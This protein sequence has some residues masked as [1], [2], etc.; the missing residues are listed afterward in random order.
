MVAARKPNMGRGPP[1]PPLQ[2]F[3]G[4]GAVC[5]ATT[6][7]MVRAFSIPLERPMLS[8]MKNWARTLRRDGH[9]IYFAARDPRVPWYAKFLAIVVAGYALSPIDL[10]PDF[11]PVIGY[12]DD[13]II[14]PFGIWLVVQLV[15][16]AIMAEC[17]SKADE[18]EARPAS[19]TGMV[20]I[21]V[22]W[23]VG[24]IAL[25]WVGYAYWTG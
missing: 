15:P 22:L 7:G 3:R 20:V 25:G 13:L 6:I 17:R 10:I 1:S 24:A 16:D 5:K 23:L 11:I 12:L 18:A 21:I 9:A 4:N 19:Q 8:R 2:D 14:V